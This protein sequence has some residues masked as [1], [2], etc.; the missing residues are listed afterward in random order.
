M[1]IPGQVVKPRSDSP[2]PYYSTTD[3]ETV[4]LYHG[5]VN[6]V[7]SRLP[8]KSVQCVVTS[9]P[10]YGLRSYLEDGHEHKHMELG[11]ESSP[12]CMSPR[13]KPGFPLCGKCF[14][15]H[16]VE[17]F[18]HVRRVLRDD[19]TV[20]LNLG[21]S[22]SGGKTG[23]DDNDAATR[24]KMDAHGHGGGVKLQRTGNNGRRRY[25]SPSF[26]SGN[27]IGVPW[28]VALALQADGWVLRQDIIKWNPCPM[29][30][31]VKNRCTKAH[32]YVFLITK[33]MKYFYD[34]DAIREKTGSEMTPE[35]YQTLLASNGEEGNSDWYQRETNGVKD[36]SKS[37]NP[38]GGKSHPHGRNKRSVW[39]ISPRGYRGA[40]YAT[41]PDELPEICIKAGTSEK[42]CCTRCGAPWKRVTEEEKLIRERPRDYVKRNGQ[43]GTGNSCSNSVAGVH[44]K[45]VGWRPTCDCPGNDSPVPCVVLDPFLG[46]GTSV[47]VAVSLGRRGVGID[48]SEKYL[49]ENAIPRIEGELLSRPSTAKLIRRD[50]R[51][52]FDG[53]DWAD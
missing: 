10:Y 11:G 39:R 26:P 29:P 33:S 31:S 8:A 40:H 5:D 7:L 48:L 30:E 34:H 23:R 25:P 49:T 44:S 51:P 12:D 16:L 42:G 36:G 15:C 20:W 32:E 53:E 13:L 2:T 37:G 17:V 21:D 14:C 9:P 43:K 4:R 46:S 41:F 24:A 38:I 18:R 1:P 45:T 35:E 3:G 22:Y 28:R 52:L 27:L 6:E 47:V 50:V 19:G